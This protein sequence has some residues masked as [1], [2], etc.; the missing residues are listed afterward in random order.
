MVHSRRFPRDLGSHGAP[1][2]PV[3]QRP[4]GSETAGPL[5][6]RAAGKHGLPGLGGGGCIGKI[7]LCR[8][9]AAATSGARPHEQQ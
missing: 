7:V 9:T 3:A 6:L 2:M 8:A 1:G 4:F 5:W